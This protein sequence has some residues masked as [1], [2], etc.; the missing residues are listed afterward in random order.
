MLAAAPPNP[1][2]APDRPAR[3]AFARVASMV[4]EVREFLGSLYN[5]Y[6]DTGPQINWT[7][8]F[9]GELEDFYRCAP[10]PGLPDPPAE[11]RYADWA[12]TGRRPDRL[13]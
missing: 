7:R 5:G 9:E 11:A 12:G 6:G 3:A 8:G 4:R 2:G 1:T 10:R 13:N